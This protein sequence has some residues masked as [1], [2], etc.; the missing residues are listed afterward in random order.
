MVF[1]EKLSPEELELSQL[2]IT[3]LGLDMEPSGLD[4][5]IPLYGG[6]LGLDS[7][8]IL[9]ISLAISKA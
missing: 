5:R 8:D 7:I 2:I 4:P 3:T 6:G 9:E 1:D